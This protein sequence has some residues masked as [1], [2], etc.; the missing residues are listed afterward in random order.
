MK[1]CNAIW[2]VA[3]IVRAA[4]DKNAQNL[5]GVMFKQ[6]LLFD[7]AYSNITMVCSKTDEISSKT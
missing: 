1:D 5:M 6:Q 2:I 3:P 4:D 7:G